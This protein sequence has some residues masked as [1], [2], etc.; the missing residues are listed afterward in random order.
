[1]SIQIIRTSAKITKNTLLIIALGLGVALL[2][3]LAAPKVTN[4]APGLGNPIGPVPIGPVGFL[5]K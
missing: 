5:P 2:I 3:A 4:A 1:M